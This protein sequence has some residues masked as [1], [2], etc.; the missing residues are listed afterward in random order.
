MRT[1]AQIYN[2]LVLLAMI[3]DLPGSHAAAVSVSSLAEEQDVEMYPATNTPPPRYGAPGHGQDTGGY[4]DGKLYNPFRTNHRPMCN[5]IPRWAYDSPEIN[6]FCGWFHGMGAK[7]VLPVP[8]IVTVT[9][10]VVIPK[11]ST[12]LVNGL[13]TTVTLTITNSVTE[14][15]T[16]NLTPNPV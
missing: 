16:T 14:N 10:T 12:A 11:T 5:L 8:V 1:P 4:D 3:V 9:R 15:S 2:G 7:P 6:S 13:P